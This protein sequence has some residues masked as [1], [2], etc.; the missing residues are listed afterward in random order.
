MPANTAKVVFGDA[1]DGRILDG[2]RAL[3]GGGNLQ[4]VIVDPPAD[5]GLPGTVEIISVHDAEWA[6]RCADEYAALRRARGADV[7]DAAAAVQ[8]PLL[9][10]A[11]YTRLGYMEVDRR[12]EHGFARVFMRKVLP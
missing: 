10:M 1:H 12:V 3:S 9:F 4:P 7:G 2:V 5:A 6:T 8:D 11:L